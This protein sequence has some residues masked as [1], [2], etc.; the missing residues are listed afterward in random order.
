MKRESKGDQ[1]VE[2]WAGVECSVVR[3]G[4]RYLDQVVS[5]G[6][7]DRRGDLDRL[8]ELGVRAVRYPVLWERTAP[9]R[10]EDADWSFADERLAR[11]R[12][13]GMRPIV[14]LVHH[15]SGPR[16]TSLLDDSFVSGLARFARAVAERYPWIEDYTPINEPLTTAR[17]SALYGHWYPHAKSD[18]AFHRALLVQCEATRA[19]I[20]AIR[21]VTPTARLVQTEDAATVLSTPHLAYQAE[22]EN[23]RRFASLDLLTGRFGA[24]HPLRRFFVDRGADARVLDSFAFEPCPP[25][26]IGINYYV[27]SDR[28]LDERV[29]NY[30]PPV[31]GGNERESYADV[32][33]VRVHRAGIMGHRRVLE[34]M[35]A[36]Y[37]LP[38]AVTEVHLGCHPEE[39]VR[40]LAEAWTGAN[41][42]LAGGV[43]VRG[44]TV[45]SAF[46]AHDWDS[47][48]VQ[49]RGHYEPGLFDVRGGVVRPTALASVA[50]ELATRGES[51]H[52]VLAEPGWWRRRKRLVY[53]SSGG[54]E[55][56]HACA[57]AARPILIT[58][59]RGTLGHA[60]A[61]TC[62][63]R[64]LPFVALG[65]A[66]LDVTDEGAVAEAIARLR[67][68]AVVNA[69]G[70]VRVDDAE[71]DRAR[72]FR[73]NAHAVHGLARACAEHGVRL[74]T[75]SSDL[76]FD[77]QK[78][79][80]YVERDPSSPLGVYGLSKA[81]A[82]RH[83]LATYA[84]AL[85]V[86]TSAFF[87]PWDEASF[88]HATLAALRSHR[89]VRAPRD[90]VV[91]P[92]YVPDLAD[93]LLTLLVDGAEGI[94]HVAGT[95]AVSWAELARRAARIAGVQTATLV[96]CSTSELGLLAARPAYSALGSE[97]GRLM[98]PLDETLE[99]FVACTAERRAHETP[100]AS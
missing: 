50:R 57:R 91:S 23:Q 82:E 78:T 42:A 36:R 3:V 8:A 97:R 65:R 79:S 32:E 77:G 40:W 6:H 22:F 98:G 95:E 72:C 81:R 10:I 59:A 53:P 1:R 96:A 4:D 87:G 43:D 14:G 61:R 75:I 18:H 13:L 89:V 29:V 100:A 27:T 19:A 88:V 58:G 37:G 30:P 66:E 63:L 31:R 26:V 35:W 44:V 21:E 28:F 7:Q 99:R 60:V 67:P 71:H 74:A 92:T 9:G 39:Q 73:D 17:F 56:E 47:L 52:P 51:E 33:A 5:T 90:Q 38:L 55:V 16:E 69:A 76:V 41:E 20:R 80:P 83:V 12:A 34:N 86:R 68:W 49:S 85:V 62:A 24:T 93:A 2:L 94:W 54:V 15:G 84:S 45:W 46:G 11:I 48:L 70:Y 25:D 64:D